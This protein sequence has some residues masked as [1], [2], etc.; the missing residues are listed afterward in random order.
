MIVSKIQFK[1]ILILIVCG[2]SLTE[3]KAATVFQQ[4]LSAVAGAGACGG[5]V[6][7]VTE[8]NKPLQ[9]VPFNGSLSSKISSSLSDGSYANANADISFGHAH[10]YADA[11]RTFNAS[12]D[13]L[14][15]I[16]VGD[17][18]SQGSVEQIDYIDTSNLLNSIYKF[19]YDVHG[20]HTL[21]DNTYPNNISAYSY[22]YYSITDLATDTYLDYGNWSSSDASPNVNIIKNV[23]VPNGDTIAVRVE[24][25]ANAYVMSNN[26]ASYLTAVS[27]YSH[28]LDVYIDPV[29]P[30]ANTTGISGHDYASPIP[31]APSICLFGSALLGYLGLKRL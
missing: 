29:T 20:S 3:V 24:F 27:D 26:A 2:L 14:S 13:S 16:I 18:Q 23:L 22:L 10:V 25:E 30:G 12:L 5:S 8:D 31:V 4:Q 1:K 6:G 21:T 9:V 7:C 19:Q 15:G 28:T 17:A 11:H